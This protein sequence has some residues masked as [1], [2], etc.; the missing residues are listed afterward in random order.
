MTTDFRLSFE[1]FVLPEL[2]L[3]SLTS[4]E[5][6]SQDNG[7]ADMSSG[8]LYA[9][10]DENSSTEYFT[11]ISEL[12]YHNYQDEDGSENSEEEEGLPEN[13]KAEQTEKHKGSGFFMRQLSSTFSIVPSPRTPKTPREEL[14]A[15][16]TSRGNMY[17]QLLRTWKSREE[18]SSPKGSRSRSL[19][20]SGA[21]SRSVLGSPSQVAPAI[22]SSQQIDSSCEKEDAVKE[23]TI[24]D[25]ELF[26]E[27][28][29]DHQQQMKKVLTRQSIDSG[30]YSADG[31]SLSDLN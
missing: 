19:T 12:P 24:E 10:E 2:T 22:I 27:T 5:P 9:Q 15:L 4:K 26:L 20:S 14:L 17:N 25:D 28:S 6:R 11:P 7:N 30:V 31:I 29:P 1:D 13:N 23:H 18:V 16:R 21:F 3:E 8:L